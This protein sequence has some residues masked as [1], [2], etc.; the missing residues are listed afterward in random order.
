MQEASPEN[1]VILYIG[2]ESLTLTNL[3][4][5]HASYEVRTISASEDE[6]D[7][8]L[9]HDPVG[10]HIRSKD[11]P[12]T[13]RIRTH[14]QAPHAPLCR[15]PESARRRRH[16]YPRW[17]PR[18]RCVRPSLRAL[19]S[20]FASSSELNSRI[21]FLNSEL[22][23]AHRAPP[24]DHQARAQEVVHDQ[25][26]QGQPREARQLPRG[27]DLR[28]RR[29]PREQPPRFQ[30]VPPSDRHPV[31]AR[32]RAAA[33]GDVDGAVRARLRAALAGAGGGAGRGGVGGCVSCFT[34]SPSTSCQDMAHG[35][36]IK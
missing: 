29:V 9:M 26:R 4:M 13:A 2:G 36:T 27:R 28:P 22:P 30:G 5:T 10:V 1:S 34:R 21:H 24:H 20:L 15:R 12:L 14:K 35:S 11:W 25:R 7:L 18:R 31:R 6:R 32:D 23:A 33:G 16:R 17:Y 8:R 19:P 3:L